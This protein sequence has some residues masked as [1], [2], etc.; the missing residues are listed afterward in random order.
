M[1]PLYT[2]TMHNCTLVPAVSVGRLKTGTLLEERGRVMSERERPARLG[3][4]VR[5]SFMRNEGRLAEES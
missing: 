2:S 3:L 1:E 4:F 5:S